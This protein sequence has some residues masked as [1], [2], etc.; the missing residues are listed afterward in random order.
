MGLFSIDEDRELVQG[1]GEVA[2]AERR[3]KGDGGVVPR[4]LV[5]AAVDHVLVIA[6]RR[7]ESSEEDLIKC[8]NSL[9]TSLVVS[10]VAITYKALLVEANQQSSSVPSFSGPSTPKLW[11]QDGSSEL[12]R[13]IV[14]GASVS[15]VRTEEVDPPRDA[16]LGGVVEGEEFVSLPRGFVEFSNCLGIL[17]LDF[18]KEINSLLRKLEAKKGCGVK[19]L[20]GRQHSLSSL[21]L[22]KEI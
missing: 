3:E 22:E 17:V 4:P 6:K 18:E 15:E 11:V 19:V 1:S 14:K 7:E 9:S 10:C 21:R 8:S 20:G 13:K 2:S 16:D 5:V 12:S